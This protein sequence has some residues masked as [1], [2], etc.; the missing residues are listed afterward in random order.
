MPFPDEVR[1][2]AVVAYRDTWPSEFEILEGALRQAL[3]ALAIGIDHIGST[4]VPGLPA[5]D[6]IDVQV[7]VATLDRLHIRA[8]FGEIGFRL[9]PEP[10]NHLER[11]GGK[12]VPK[13]VFAPPAGDR[14]AN[15]HVR[16]DGSVTA[17]VALLF[18]DFLRADDAAR[19]HWGTF[20]QELAA[21]APDL[22]A[23][24]QAKAPAWEV[25]MA[26]AEQWASETKWP[27]VLNHA[28][29]TSGKQAPRS[30]TP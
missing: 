2:V 4:S 23:Y 9:R 5:K 19:I 21:R 28:E 10:W 12:S 27:N 29:P 14:L 22:E 24:G 18:R 6:V 13:L 17:R 25:L 3:K 26:R 20:K 1:A 15:V 11:Y 16:T 30:P 7:R 8:A